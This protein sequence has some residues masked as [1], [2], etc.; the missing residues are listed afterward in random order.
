MTTNQINS[1]QTYMRLEDGKEDFAFPR[2][3]D[4][5]P[6]DEYPLRVNAG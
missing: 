5:A 1:K 2:I 3:E 4:T 6:T